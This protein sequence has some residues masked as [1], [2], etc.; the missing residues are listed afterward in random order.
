M[1]NNLTDDTPFEPIRSGNLVA[2]LANSEA[3][4]DA[5]Q[6]LRYRVFF[7]EMKARPS[8]ENVELGRDFDEFDQLCDH[9]LVIADDCPDLPGGVIG[10]YRLL[11]RGIAETGIGFYTADEYD[12]SPLLAV[13]GEILELGR[14][15]VD[16]RHRTRPTMQLL[17]QTIAAYLWHHDIKLMFGCASLPGADPQQLTL[18]LSYL[19]HFHLGPREMRPVALSE[20]YIDMACIAK[21]EIDTRRALTALPPLIKGYIRLGGF[22]GDGAVVDEQFNTTDV[23]V[24]VKTD[25]VTGKYIKHFERNTRRANVV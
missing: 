2:R 14:S 22:V 1:D 9:L 7:E 11:R 6:A 18:E 16:V 25:L 4:V 15:C 3:D 17:W 8:A 20:R 13:D 24:V 5:A 21:S 23:C 19:H 12:I 10:T